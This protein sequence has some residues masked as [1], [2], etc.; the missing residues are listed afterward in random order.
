[1]PLDF[2]LMNNELVVYEVAG[3]QHP[4]A[5]LPWSAPTVRLR[6][7]ALLPSNTGGLAELAANRRWGALSLLPTGSY[8]R[9][10][11]KRCSRTTA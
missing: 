8:Q 1:M 9:P 7:W 4:G 10:D 11:V 5:S 2:P 6:Q 3:R